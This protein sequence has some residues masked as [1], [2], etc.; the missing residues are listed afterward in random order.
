MSRKFHRPL[1]PY[2]PQR[3]DRGQIDCWARSLASWIAATR[4]SPLET[5]SPDDILNWY[6]DIVG[7]GGM[8]DFEKHMPRIAS[9]WGMAT[10][11]IGGPNFTIDYI[12]WKLTHHSHMYV[13]YPSIINPGQP[14]ISHAIVVYGILGIDAPPTQVQAMD[15]M[16]GY[17]DFDLSYFSSLRTM[18]VGY[19]ENWSL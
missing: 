11:I 3:T 7:D 5:W 2:N 6:S 18:F 8:L 15:P 16:R 4:Y 19:I 9:D 17:P 12:Y 14:P 10:E 1:P 13:V